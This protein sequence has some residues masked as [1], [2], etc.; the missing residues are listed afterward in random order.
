MHTKRNRLLLIATISILALILL[1][2]YFNRAKPVR[3]LVK[4]VTLGKVYATVAN[5]RAGTV[6]ACRRAR[7]SPSISGQIALLPVKEGERV[8]KDQLLLEI[9]NDDL[10]AQ[11]TLATSEARASLATAK[12]VCVTAEVATREAKRLTSLRR[13]KLTSIEKAESAVGNAKANQAACEAANAIA[14]V[15]DARL[16]VAK[17]ALARTRLT[18]PFDGTIAEVNGELGEVVTPSPVGV[19]TP[20]AIDIVDTSC[21]YVTAPIDEVDAPQVRAGM[22][23]QISLDAFNKTLFPAT[24]K[25]VAPY[26]MDKEKQARTVNIEIAFNEPDKLSNMLPGYSADAEIILKSKAHVL[27][28]PTEAL[29]EDNKVLVFTGHKQAL[30]QRQ[31][32]TGISNWRYTEVLSGLKQG[33]QIVISVD[34]D[35]VEEG[36]IAIL[37]KNDKP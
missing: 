28:I 10:V 14:Q 4:P 35:G 9:W 36:A 24:V 19:A 26:V 29:L 37:D 33:E 30:V 23:A 31:I 12:Q 21:L 27:R 20:P 16:A 6:K 18:A 1:V 13:K 22:P 2:T 34:R 8:K 5:T 25:R 7:L 17:A 32:K 15:S 11:V 3:V